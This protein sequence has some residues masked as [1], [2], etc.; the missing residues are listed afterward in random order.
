[1]QDW[2]QDKKDVQMRM[3]TR[4]LV[5]GYNEKTVIKDMNLLFPETGFT[6]LLGPNGAG[7]STLLKALTGFLPA[8]EGVVLCAG[9]DVQTWN[10]RELAQKLAF[11]PQELELQFA[12]QVFEF[13]LMGRFPYLS[14]WQNYSSRDI[15]IVEEVLERLNLSAFRAKIVQELSGGEKQRVLIARALVQQTEVMLLDESL[16]QLDISYQVEI[17]QVLHDIAHKDGKLVVLVSHNINLA[18]NYCDHIILLQ[19][20]RSV[21]EGNPET[22]IRTELLQQVYGIQ[23][24]VETNPISGK[25]NF[26]YPG[27]G[28]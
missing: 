22:V 25:P 14:L 24:Q 2:Q 28:V 7:K 27:L 21:A 20:G 16:S 23:L 12:Y 17:M 9:K 19:D 10:K 13:V 18:A 26:Y 1:V 4:N 6:A 5:C 15:I 3:E 8:R 11:I